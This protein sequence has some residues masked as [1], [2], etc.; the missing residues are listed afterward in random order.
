MKNFFIGLSLLL[1]PNFNHDSWEKA[2]YESLVHSEAPRGIK[3]AVNSSVMIHSMN[4]EK[5]LSAGSGNL[6]KIKGEEVI[7]TA[8]HVVKDGLFMIAVEKNNNTVA[9]EL[10]Y[11]DEEKDIAVLKPVEKMIVTSAVKLKQRKDNHIGKQV[12][13]CGHPSVVEFNLSRGMITSF[14]RG[15]IIVDSFSLPGS[16]GSVV[17]GE[18]G[19]V[20]GIV[21]AI[22][23]GQ[24]FDSPELID[25]VVIVVPL[26]YLDIQGIV[27]ALENG[28]TRI[29]SRDSN[30]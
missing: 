14:N 1:Q 12:Y 6:L 28:T 23:M 8:Y 11:Y 19:D 3:Y 20:I 9:V 10:I 16:S 26:D 22:A 17:F 30:N 4:V 18:R 13:H 2:Y 7:V 29:E 25:S 21:T 5:G 27:E 24:W 15:Q